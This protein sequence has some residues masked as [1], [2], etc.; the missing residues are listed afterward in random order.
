MARIVYK[1]LSQLTKE[2]YKIGVTCYKLFYITRVH[3]YESVSLLVFP[4]SYSR[5]LFE[6]KVRTHETVKDKYNMIH[7]TL[8]KISNDVME[9][10][11]RERIDDIVVDLVKKYFSD[12]NIDITICNVSEYDTCFLFHFF[13]YD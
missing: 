9:M 11:G 6:V 13:F 12:K 8:L 4:S 5:S 2:L 3:Y 1:D 7:S 10:I